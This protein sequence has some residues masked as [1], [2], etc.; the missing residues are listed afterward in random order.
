MTNQ[1]TCLDGF[2]QSKSNYLR[3]YIKNGLCNITNH[4]S[5]TLVMLKKIPVRKNRGSKKSEVFSGYGSFKDGFPSWVSSKD[6]K[7]LQS[8]VNQTTYNLVVAK[9][10]TGNFTTI[11]EA[12]DAAPNSSAT[13]LI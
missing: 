1:G 9:D 2:A 13:R 10:G 11:S 4:V 12:V 3:N 5:N 6:R 7:L 8:S